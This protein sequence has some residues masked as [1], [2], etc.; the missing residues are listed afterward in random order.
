MKGKYRKLLVLG[1]DAALPDLLVKFAG[2]RRPTEHHP[3]DGQGCILQSP[4]GIPPSD[5]GGVVGDRHGSRSLV[6]P[7]FPSLMVK[8]PGEEL[9]EWHTSFD[10]RMLVAETLWE[11]AGEKGTEDGPDQLAG[12]LARRGV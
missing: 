11:T 8:L 1:L 2:G 12:D 3:A 10:R 9:D 7:A 4:H 6:R 5:G